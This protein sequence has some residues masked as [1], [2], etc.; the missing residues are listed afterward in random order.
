MNRPKYLYNL[1]KRTVF[2]LL[3]GFSCVFI[4]YVVFI[5]FSYFIEPYYSNFIGYLI[6]SLVSFLLNKKFTFKSKNTKLSLKRYFLIIA[7]GFSVSQL[8]IFFGVDV[9]NFA[10]SLSQIKVVAIMAAASLQ[11][12]C[13]TFFGSTEKK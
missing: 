1:K 10:N 6:G 8:V 13:N 4:D 3:I 9:F 12:C 11:Y 5:Q 7:L 2:Y